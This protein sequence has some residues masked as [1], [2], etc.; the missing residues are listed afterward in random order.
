MKAAISVAIFAILCSP[1]LFAAAPANAANEPSLERLATCQD[2]W[3][4]WKDDQARATKFAE[5]LRANYAQKSNEAYL[6]PKSAKK[7]FGMPVEAVYPESVGMAV[8]FS[9]VVTSGFDAT[10]K[11]IEKAL[12]KPLQCDPHTDEMRTCQF[13]KG[14]KKTVVLM[15][16]SDK[17][18]TKSTLV[19]C[20]YF[21]EK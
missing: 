1:S 12:G 15:A 14:P 8:G 21:Y 11:T 2:S 19:G 10:K 4:D 18:D 20:Y 5:N 7:L 6:V 3:F 9:V 17:A 13:E 16:G